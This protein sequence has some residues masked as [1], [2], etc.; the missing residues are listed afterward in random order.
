MPPKSKSQSKSK[1][2]DS[3]QTDVDAALH[4]LGIKYVPP[5]NPTQTHTPA[6]PHAETIFVPP[7]NP[8][9]TQTPSQTQT[10]TPARPH[11]ETTIEAR[12]YAKEE[13]LP[14]GWQYFHSGRIVS[15]QNTQCGS[16]GAAKAVQKGEEWAAEFYKKEKERYHV[17]DETIESESE[18]ESESSS[19][20]P[21]S[22]TEPES[23]PLPPQPAPQLTPQSQPLVKIRRRSLLPGFLELHYRAIKNK[24]SF[25]DIRNHFV[26][27]LDG[28][29]Q[30]EE[31][32]LL[33][34]VLERD[35]AGA[36]NRLKDSS[37][38]AERCLNEIYK[39]D[40]CGHTCLDLMLNDDGFVGLVVHV[41]DHITE[42]DK[43][44]FKDRAYAAR[45]NKDSFASQCN[46]KCLEDIEK[47]RQHFERLSQNLAETQEVIGEILFFVLN[48]DFA[49][50]VNRLSNPSIG[51]DQLL[52]EIGKCDE[53][54]RNSLTIVLAKHEKEFRMNEQLLEKFDEIGRALFEKDFL[55][56]DKENKER[57]K[58]ISLML[59]HVATNDTRAHAKRAYA[60]PSPF[61][62]KSEKDG[63]FRFK[64]DVDCENAQRYFRAKGGLCANQE[65]EGE[66]LFFVN[67]G[68]FA[69]ATAR[70][71]NSTLDEG[72]ILKEIGKKNEDLNTAFAVA[73][74]STKGAKTVSLMLDFIEKY[75]TRQLTSRAFAQRSFDGFTAL[76]HAADSIDDLDLVKRLFSAF[77]AAN[78]MEVIYGKFHDDCGNEFMSHPWCFANR[79]G[80][81]KI[82]KFL[83]TQTG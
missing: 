68:D 37:I 64:T 10:H 19:G 26:S 58:A 9:Q 36:A 42:H 46:I 83:H 16:M 40:S 8:T 32:E 52:S 53:I 74:S 28:A 44:A 73:C 31:G 78:R 17:S 71:L 21:E 15:P 29:T 62:R 30:E 24:M 4:E 6:R 39:R 23:I 66:I 70:L 56:H 22:D 45:H 18:S 81:E 49:G 2:T 69:G 41:I 13:G 47:W 77:P 82:S 34:L 14:D 1:S 3:D 63:L 38:D 60:H 20:T 80:N 33:N 54:G 7:Q 55:L 79:R 51:A 67:K 48:K 75:D 76:H 43:R 35:F 57:A 50:A 65:V 11:A 12:G 72:K 25:A 61:C 5:Q 59:D 27:K